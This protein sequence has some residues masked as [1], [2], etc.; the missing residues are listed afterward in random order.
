MLLGLFM[1]EIAHSLEAESPLLG[2]PF[3]L[4]LMMIVAG[5]NEVLRDTQVLISCEHGPL[6]TQFLS[7]GI[8]S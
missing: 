3:C 6:T 7:I 4:T 8:T 2:S 1:N 5:T